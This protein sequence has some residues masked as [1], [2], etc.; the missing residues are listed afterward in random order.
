MLQLSG[1]ALTFEVCRL[2]FKPSREPLHAS[3]TLM[4]DES[5]AFVSKLGSF[6]IS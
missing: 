4:N 1:L 2:T 6:E 3:E 5:H